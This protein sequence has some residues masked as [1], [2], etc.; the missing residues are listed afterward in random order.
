MQT[1][2]VAI[3][4][5]DAVPDGYISRRIELKLSPEHAV[6]VARVQRH[7]AA[8]RPAGFQDVSPSDAVRHIIA[9]L[10]EAMIE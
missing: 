5:T 8:I 9:K 4:A 6:A 7:L 2:A 10:A 3:D 1:F